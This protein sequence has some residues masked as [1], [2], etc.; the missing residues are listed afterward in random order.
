M[1]FSLQKTVSTCC[2]L[3]VVS[4]F[5]FTESGDKRKDVL[6][7]GLEN[8]IVELINNLEQRDDHSLN[9]EIEDL[10]SSTRSSA[11]RES[12]LSFYG[13]QQNS[14]FA[15][16]C[17][18]VLED[19]YIHRNST[20]SA[21]FQYVQ[22]VPIRE[23]APLVKS[24]LSNES[25]EFRDQAIR[26]LGKIGTEEDSIYLF[27]Y[28]QSN[29]PGDE[30]QR[31]I[32]RQNVMTALGELKSEAAWEDFLLVAQ[33]EEENTM[34]RATAARAIGMIGKEGGVAVLADLFE[35][36]DPILRGAVVNALSGYSDHQ[37]VSVVLEG[38]KDTHYR[39][40]LEALDAVKKQGAKKA[41]PFVQYRAENDPVEA[42]KMKSLDV[43]ASLDDNDSTGWMLEQIRDSKTPDKVRVRMITVLMEHK[44]NV[45]IEDAIQVAFASLKDDKKKWMRYELGKLFAKY[46][47][48]ALSAVA[49][50][51]ITHADTL[52]KGIGI[53]LYNKNR[54]S[55]LK[56]YVEAIAEND[57]MGGLQSQAK[58]ALS[59]K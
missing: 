45:V 9:G 32:I 51:Y 53:E 37:A 56:S 59:S 50:S 36:E 49:E 8:E 16:Y 48:G 35:T 2:I 20:V 12:I 27:E 21:V 31:L 43:L 39:V 55:N 57:K 46:D 14:A 13:S 15:E 22:K 58:R 44:K 41:A 19:P 25:E 42:V 38:L 10:F 24:L 26:T 30:R 28:L 3:L 34:I 47:D 23:A 54:F 52:T 5:L 33:D 1:I 6:K 40:R 11:V 7:Y 17:I 18:E 29:I 4:S